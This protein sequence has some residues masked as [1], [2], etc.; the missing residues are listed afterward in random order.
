MIYY[1]ILWY[2]MLWCVMLLYVILYNTMLLYAMDQIKQCRDCKTI[3]NDGKELKCKGEEKVSMMWY[4]LYFKKSCPILQLSLFY[5][6]T[7]D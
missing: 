5:D 3:K 4:K 2:S 6:I 1:T 7:L